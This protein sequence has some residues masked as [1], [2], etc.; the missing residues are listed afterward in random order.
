M[1]H[2]GITLSLVLL[3]FHSFSQELVLH[4]N[5]C[6]LAHKKPL[7]ESKTIINGGRMAELSCALKLHEGKEIF[8]TS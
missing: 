3:P 7:M 5:T 1:S 8:Y 2:S 4:L 6:L